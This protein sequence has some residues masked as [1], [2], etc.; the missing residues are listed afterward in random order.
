MLAPRE[1]LWSA[2][3]EVVAEAAR[4]LA[5]RS[6]DVFYDIGAGDGRMLLHVAS[7]ECPPRAAIGVEI[8]RERA[9]SVVAAIASRGLEGKCRMINRNAL[10]LSYDDA[11]AVFLYL[12]PR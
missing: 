11:T 6:D 9:E 7:I 2:P 1:K 3:A 4:L 8:N 5:I 10:E 12:V